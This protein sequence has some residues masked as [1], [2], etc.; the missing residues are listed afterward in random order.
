MGKRVLLKQLGI[1]ILCGDHKFLCYLMIWLTQIWSIIHRRLYSKK[2]DETAAVINGILTGGSIQ[3]SVMP[4]VY[5]T[6]GVLL[7][8]DL[9][10]S[11]PNANAPVSSCNKVTA[12]NGVRFV[13][14]ALEDFEQVCGTG[15]AQGA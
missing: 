8:L 2:I 14:V 6:K 4:R 3:R 1:V 9:V 7:I 5:V 12:V 13:V 11:E 15:R 10:D